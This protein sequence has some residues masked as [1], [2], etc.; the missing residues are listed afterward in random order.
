MKTVQPISS[1]KTGGLARL[2]EERGIGNDDFQRYLVDRPNELVAYIM[3]MKNANPF[4][5]EKVSPEWTYPVGWSKSDKHLQENR[6]I[7]AIPGFKPK[8][9]R[10]SL[11]GYSPETYDGVAIIPTILSLGLLWSIY[12]PHREGYGK[13][14]DKL[15]TI[16]EERQSFKNDLRGKLGPGNI[17]LHKEVIEILLPLEEDAFRSG[18]NCLLMPLSFGKKYAGHSNRNCRWQALKNGELPLGSAQGFCLLLTMPGRLAGEHDLTADWPGDCYDR[19]DYAERWNCM[20]YHYFEK[21][22][23]HFHASG[24]SFPN[25]RCGPVVGFPLV[26]PAGLMAA[27]E[28]KA[29]D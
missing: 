29:E 18:C 25:G 12:K 19:Q 9:W 28:I 20:T 13:V 21:G 24:D 1:R 5:S 11:I 3:A 15:A 26:P 22:E 16:L 8:Y 14:V 10:P 27:Y 17:R 4:E 2:L 6:L 7:E 23:I